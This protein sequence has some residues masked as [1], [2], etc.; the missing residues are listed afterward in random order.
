MRQSQPTLLVIDDDDNLRSLLEFV[1]RKQYQVV[2]RSN[3]LEALAWLGQSPLPAAILLD[4]DMP[5]V[6]GYELLHQLKASG[7]YHEIPIVML[8]G[9]ESLHLREA[10]LA[11][12]AGAYL[13]KPF[14]PGQLHHAIEESLGGK[15]S[16]SA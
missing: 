6:N 14:H 7:W 9:H 4:L 16:Q 12:G 2:T 10:C 8:S 11:A 3:G 15:E 1:L 13:L 5:E